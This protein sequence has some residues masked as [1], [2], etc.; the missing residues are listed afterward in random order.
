MT[1]KV[2]ISLD[3]MGG[4]FGPAVVIPGAAIAL[5]RHPDSTFVIHGQEADCLPL[6]DKHP[7]LKAATT[8]TT[9]KL[10]SVWTPSRARHC[11]KGGT[12]RPCGARSN[13]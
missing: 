13:R 8:F 4:D 6:L 7:A 1:R 2:R 5:E 9:L 10:P 11:G 12:N 3:A